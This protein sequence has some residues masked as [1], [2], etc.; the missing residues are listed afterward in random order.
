MKRNLL[1]AHTVTTDD[2]RIVAGWLVRRATS[3]KE[4]GHIWEDGGVWKWRAAGSSFFGERSTQRAA[5]DACSDSYDVA[6]GQPLSMDLPFTPAPTDA[7]ILDAW[8]SVE[9]QRPDGFVRHTT[10]A[11]TAPRAPR[12]VTPA[13]PVRHVEWKKAGQG[14]D[15][16]AAM[17]AGLRGKK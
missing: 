14:F 5:L 4:V 17:A 3:R 13:E 10:T 9:A 6:H 12:P 7:D 15:V 8:R 2:G 1:T 16:T 11:P